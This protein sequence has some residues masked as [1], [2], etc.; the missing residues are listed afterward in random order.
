MP[1]FL[2]LIAVAVVVSRLLNDKHASS[3]TWK[4]IKS[5][6]E[7]AMRDE[8]Q[9]KNA[10]PASFEEMKQAL[11]KLQQAEAHQDLLSI[12]PDDV[13]YESSVFDTIDSKEEVVEETDEDTMD[14]NAIESHQDDPYMIQRKPRFDASELRKAIVLSEVIGEPVSKRK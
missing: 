14:F 7:A 13:G 12:E 2:I 8:T 9:N 1:F 3:D 5:E 11:R 4:R 10:Q 6:F